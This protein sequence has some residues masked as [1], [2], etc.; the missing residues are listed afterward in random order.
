MG[1]RRRRNVFQSPYLLPSQI[2]GTHMALLDVVVPQLSESVAEATMLTWKKKPGEAIAIDEIL[3]EIET[4][5]VVLEVPAPGAG[6]LAEIVKGDGST[7]T[8]GEVIARIDTAAVAQAPAAAPAAQAIAAAPAAA[9]PAPAPSAPAAGIAS[10][11]A[12]KI[13]SEKG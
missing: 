8:A 10:P 6:V 5:K 3:I 12:A 7:V 1:G 4:D 2:Q 13:L 11:A 9:A